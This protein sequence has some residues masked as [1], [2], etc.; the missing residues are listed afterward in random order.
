[1]TT[2]KITTIY[3]HSTTSLLSALHRQLTD[4]DLKLLESRGLIV[5]RSRENLIQSYEDFKK[6]GL[7]DGKSF[8]GKEEEQCGE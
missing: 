5:G 7:T 2:N 4:D 8:N 6:N 1:M 3:N